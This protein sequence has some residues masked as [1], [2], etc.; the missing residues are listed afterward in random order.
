MKRFRF[1]LRPVSVIRAHREVRAR[2]RFAG[3]VQ[4]YV[5][6]EEELLSVRTRIAKFGAEL[7]QSRSGVFDAAE[8]AHCL[9]GFRHESAAEIPAERA[10]IA[11]RAEMQL[12]RAEYIEAH[13]E[14]ELVKR[15]EE[16][17][18]ARHRIACEREEQAEFDDLAGR[19]SA[20]RATA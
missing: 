13:R 7:A 15:I 5:H 11:A 18:R 9:E 10:V 20:Q 16:K 4:A 2:E 12:R 14:L 19:R 17:T 8:Q 3:S 6:T 1:S